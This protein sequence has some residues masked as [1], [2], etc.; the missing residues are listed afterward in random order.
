M[1]ILRIIWEELIGMF[2]D[3]GA[4]ALLAI[5]LIVCITVAVKILSIDPLLGGGLLLFGYLLI[6]AESVSRYA[7]KKRQ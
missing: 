7:R 2:I 3:D 1:T 4:L 6:L 5:A